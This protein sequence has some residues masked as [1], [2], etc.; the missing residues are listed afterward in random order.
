VTQACYRRVSAPPLEQALFY[1]SYRVNASNAS[2]V[3]QHLDTLVDCF[4]V[5]APRYNSH[6]CGRETKSG[7]AKHSNGRVPDLT[8]DMCRIFSRPP[9][10]VRAHVLPPTAD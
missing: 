5:Y 2:S 6:G 8:N 1:L 9:H 3:E 10:W 7:L 4:D